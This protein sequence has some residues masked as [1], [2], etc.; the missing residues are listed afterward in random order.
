LP[1]TCVAQVITDLESDGQIAIA[2]AELIIGGSLISVR[3]SPKT[4][5]DQAATASGRAARQR[6]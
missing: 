4:R 3:I 5:E 2:L 1:E 6:E